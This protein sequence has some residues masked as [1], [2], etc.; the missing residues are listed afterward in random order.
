MMS[1]MGDRQQRGLA[2]ILSLIFGS[3]FVMSIMMLAVETY[4][5]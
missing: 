4:L 5:W 2:A 3:L 1:N